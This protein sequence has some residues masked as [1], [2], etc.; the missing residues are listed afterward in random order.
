MNFIPSLTAGL[1]AVAGLVCAAGPILI[2]LLNRRRFQTV[3]WAAMD[4]LREALKRNRRMLE[5]RDIA[6][7]A[8]R[9]LAVFLFGL[10]LAQPFVSPGSVYMWIIV[11]PAVILGLLL[12][13]VAA[14]LWSEAIFRWA[15]VAGAA[16]MFGLA[17]V[18]LSFQLGTTDEES[19]KF[20]GAQPLHAVLLIDN[21]MSMGYQ[22]IDGRLMD[23]AKQRAK[24]FV[25]RL[26]E[27]SPVS[28]VPLCGSRFGVSS[29][30]YSKTAAVEA[31]DQIDVVDR[32]SNLRD[33]AGAATVAS[34][35]EPRL[36]K[37]IVLFTDQQAGNWEGLTDPEQFQ[38]LPEMQIVNVSTDD[39]EN[40]WISDFRIEDGLADVETPTTFVVELQHQGPEPRRDLQVSL[41]VDDAEVSTKTVTLE[42]GQGAREVRFEHLFNFVAVEPG[43]AA[44]VPVRASIVPDKLP[45]DDQRHLI[46]QVVAA[47]PV[48]FIDQYSDDQ[49]NPRNNV[50]GETK[51]LRKY[52]AP[53]TSRSSRDRHL[54]QVRHLRFDQVTRDQ[55]A[56][57]RLVV[58]AGVADPGPSLL[59]LLRQYVQQGGQL[60][61]AAGSAFDPVAWNQADSVETAGLLPGRLKPELVGSLPEN[62]TSQ[63]K[64]VMLSYDSMASHY[65]FRLADT[66]KDELSD[67]YSLPLFFRFVDVDLSE[68]KLADIK[69]REA[70]RLAK[71]IAALANL[72][73][74]GEDN[75]DTV[76]FPTGSSDPSWLLWRGGA[77]G[78][79]LESLPG[80]EEA[81]KEA[82][83]Q[84]VQKALPRVLARF[85]NSE[86]SPF[87]LE[88]SIGQG[89]VLFVASGLRSSWNTLHMTNTIV[90]FD[91]I[92][93]SMIQSTLPPRNFSTDQRIA[94]P[95][96]TND[97][98]VSLAL[99]RPGEEET[100]EVIDTGF[101]AKDQRGY[102]I[103]NSLTGGFYRVAETDQA[104][105]EESVLAETSVAVN[106][107]PA[108]SDLGV[109]SSEQFF[110]RTAGS[111]LRLVGPGGE[112]SLAGAQAHGQDFYWMLLVF[113]VI[114]FLLAELCILAWPALRSRLATT[115]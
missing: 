46:A 8:L 20:D 86:E 39:L 83:D 15:S 64:P 56:D 109:L 25:E 92:L 19:Q 2:H 49:E 34:Q 78:S 59:P 48:V 112:I 58:V 80:D 72:D 29:D 98:E 1:F 17:A 61:I 6:L 101:I 47:L 26:P 31:I 91:R 10:A 3:H 97:R 115:S 27:G 28:V 16:A 32:G 54:V 95:L 65:F 114:V 22:S 24:Q 13:I 104:S 14:A 38:R 87:L 96:E 73:S 108:E 85:E 79:A 66:S 71:K 33:A 9:C 90:I 5:M 102:S 37:R 63:L 18:V 12:M 35:A 68:Q 41:F 67:L 23:A 42:P 74:G 44:F 110:Q 53:I 82:L 81:K 113:A 84:L 70:A 106:C 4:F 36:A 107:P 75:S 55:L 30:T 99:Y 43:R 45:A 52:M 105:D 93:R 69:K 60:V 51:A 62:A 88:R 7:L 50:V 21:S 11:F 94:L 89:N 40:T 103:A 77:S 76:D 100:P 57:A 111:N